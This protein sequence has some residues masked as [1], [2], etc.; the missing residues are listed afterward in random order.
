MQLRK[1]KSTDCA[2]MAQLFYD[3]VHSVNAADYTGQQLHA[4]AP[5]IPNLTAWDSS[6]SSH[7][8]IV[9]VDGETILGFGDI[10]PSGYLDRLFVH[11]NH[12]RQGIAT[13]ICDNLE[14]AVSVFRITVAASI[15]ARPFFEKRGYQ[16]LLEQQVQ[17][18]GVVLT[19]YKME[20]ILP[21]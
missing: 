1:Y 21:R 2:Q 11:K 19:N 8:S 6:F 12:Q 13:A 18:N 14:Q 7:Y 15:T 3:T 5:D 10:H 17:R 16:I 20:K 4:W 9:A